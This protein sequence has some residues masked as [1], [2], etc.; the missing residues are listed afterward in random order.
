MSLPAPLRPLAPV[1]FVLVG[2]MTVEFVLLV[3]G[4]WQ[5]RNYWSLGIR[6]GGLV[7]TLLVG[8]WVSRRVKAVKKALDLPPF[9][10]PPADVMASLPPKC[11]GFEKE[12]DEFTWLPLSRGG[13]PYCLKCWA[14]SVERR[15]S[16]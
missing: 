16:T 2:L 4:E 7:A 8:F 15:L 14:A 13:P 1:L 11:D 3:V 10:Y 12:C 6:L 9:E 5:D